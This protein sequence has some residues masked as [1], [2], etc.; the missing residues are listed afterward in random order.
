MRSPPK[1]IGRNEIENSKRDPDH[2]RPK[3]KI[4]NKKE[5]AAIHYL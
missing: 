5:V 1:N 4:P 3:E 2:K